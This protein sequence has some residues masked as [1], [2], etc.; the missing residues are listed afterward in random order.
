[1]RGARCEVR[2]ARQRLCPQPLQALLFPLQCL[3]HAQ[4][5]TNNII[6]YETMILLASQ[7]AQNSKQAVRRKDQRQLVGRQRSQASP[8][9]SLDICNSGPQQQRGGDSAAAPPL[10]EPRRPRDVGKAYCK[11][12]VRRPAS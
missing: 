4:E 3:F 12:S 11:L 5:D 7:S 2:G 9:A 1:M 8:A 10:R 6:V